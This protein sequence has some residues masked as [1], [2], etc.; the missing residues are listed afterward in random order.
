MMAS[1]SQ[2]WGYES[3]GVESSAVACG[4]SYLCEICRRVR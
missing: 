2:Q 3:V 1:C 4:S